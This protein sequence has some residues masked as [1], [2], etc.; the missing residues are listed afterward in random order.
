M[1]FYRVS[2]EIFF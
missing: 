1:P 2:Y